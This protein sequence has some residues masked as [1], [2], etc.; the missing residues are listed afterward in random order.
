[1]PWHEVWQI[2][3]GHAS[4]CGRRTAS[5][6]GRDLGNSGLA[7]A[8]GV[9]AGPSGDGGSDRSA[10]PYVQPL[11]VINSVTSTDDSRRARKAAIRSD[12]QQ[13]GVRAMPLCMPRGD[14]AVNMLYFCELFD[15]DG[16]LR[17]GLCRIESIIG[18]T[19]AFSW[20]S[21]KA[22]RSHQWGST[23]TFVPYITQGRRIEKGS[24]DVG[25]FLPVK[26][27][28]TTSS[29]RQWQEYREARSI[30]GSKVR[31]TKL[32][33]DELIEFCKVRRPELYLPTREE[34]GEEGEEGEDE[35]G[36]SDDDPLNEEEEG[37]S[38]GSG[39]E[40]ED[41]ASEGERE[42]GG[43]GSETEKDEV[44]A[45]SSRKEGGRKGVAVSQTHTT[46]TAATARAP[47]ADV[48][49]VVG[50]RVVSAPTRGRGQDAAP[51]L[52]GKGAAAAARP[53]QDATSSG[54]VAASLP[55]RHLRERMPKRRERS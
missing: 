31:L 20:L 50:A 47:T 2:L 3:H 38:E 51:A 41:C 52:A 9:E 25:A 48:G 16:E 23:P 24:V 33:M 36:D 28:Q 11:A 43:S 44:E 8:R 17:V 19:A 32:C 34:E 10:H 30:A 21:R 55:N 5:G 12:M 18:G 15:A 4:A 13:V 46:P 22:C 54:A 39:E 35:E 7:G 1:M 14:L 40:S 53:D 49:P 45:N 27:R 37:E 6:D 26:V 29:G 42:A